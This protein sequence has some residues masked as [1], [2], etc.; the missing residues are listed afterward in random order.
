MDGLDHSES[1]QSF[2]DAEDDE[3][4]EMADLEEIAMTPM[5]AAHAKDRDSESSDDEDDAGRGL[6][7]SGSRRRPGHTHTRSLSLS[8][9]IDI[10]QQ[11][12]NI[13]IEVSGHPPAARQNNSRPIDC[14]YALAYD[15]GYYVHWRVNGEGPCEHLSRFVWCHNGIERFRLG[16]ETHETDRRASNPYPRH[17]QSQRES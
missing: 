9:G 8:K 10:W 1:R 16:L 14:T 4:V 3:D 11:V 2:S 13:V 17:P 7:A 6:L 12:K 15:I 5:K